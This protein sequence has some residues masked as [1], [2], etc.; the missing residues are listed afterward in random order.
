MSRVDNPSSPRLYQP[1]GHFNAAP[2]CL[3]TGHQRTRHLAHAAAHGDAR[4]P[5]SGLI[6]PLPRLLA[7]LSQPVWSSVA[8]GPC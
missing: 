1:A 5:G 6:Q 3:S 8:E 2:S 4:P 7:M